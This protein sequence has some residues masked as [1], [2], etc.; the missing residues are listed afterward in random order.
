VG[1]L[2]N[3]KHEIFAQHVAAGTPPRE[4]YT[5]AGFEPSRANFGW[6][7]AEMSRSGAEL[8]DSRERPVA[9]ARMQPGNHQLCAS[10][11]MIASPIFFALNGSGMHVRDLRTVPVS[12]AFY[13]F[14]R[15]SDCL[16]ISKVPK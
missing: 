13:G 6:R 10:A 9:A 11:G 14:G 16:R 1:A 15:A 4:A 8:I 7:K 12:T 2:G 3:P 5:R